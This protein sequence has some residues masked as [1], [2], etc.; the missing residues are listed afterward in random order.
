[1]RNNIRKKLKELS[2]SA[3]Q[4]FKKSFKF[5]EDAC[6]GS[7]EKE[8]ILPES[9]QNDKEKTRESNETP[10]QSSYKESNRVNCKSNSKEKKKESFL[11]MNGRNGRK[12]GEARARLNLWL[13]NQGSIRYFL[14]VSE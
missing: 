8:V 3:C 13:E 14:N 11:I 7:N 4:D 5:H 9:D 1:M 2:K 12:A 6:R 10:E